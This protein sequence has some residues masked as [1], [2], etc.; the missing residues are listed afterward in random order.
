M[1]FYQNYISVGEYLY[2]MIKNKKLILYYTYSD[3]IV[4]KSN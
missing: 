2:Y 4:I 1:L 3:I